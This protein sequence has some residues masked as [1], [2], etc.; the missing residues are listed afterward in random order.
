MQEQI[1]KMMEFATKAHSAQMYDQYPYQH[2]LVC[3]FN[4]LKEVGYSE[5]VPEHIDI[6]TAGIGH[7]LLEDSATSYSDVKRLFNE[8]VAEI[9]FCM[10]DE[11]GRNRKEKKEKTYP[12]IRSNPTSIIVKLADRIANIRHSIENS[13]DSDFLK[14]YKKEYP[15]FRWQLFVPGHAIKLWTILDE[16]MEWKND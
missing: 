14:M 2:H 8:S 9:I 15:Q 6:L 12:K 4:V 16:L 11:M 13:K 1:R 10:T 3:V 7:D 5:N